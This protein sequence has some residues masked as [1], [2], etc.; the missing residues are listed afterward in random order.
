MLIF[1]GLCAIFNLL[2]NIELIR[3]GWMIG[4]AI[5]GIEFVGGFLLAYGLISKYLLEKMKMQK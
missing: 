4:L 3:M 2:I 5:I 1:I